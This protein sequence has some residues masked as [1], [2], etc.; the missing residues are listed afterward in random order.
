[1]ENKKIINVQKVIRERQIDGIIINNIKNV[2]YLTGFSGSSG[3]VVI[4]ND[5]G[6]FLTDFR[7][8]EQAL[9]EVK[10]WEICIEKGPRIKAIRGIIKKFKMN[11]IGFED[12][13]S[14][15]F[16]ESL[17]RLPLKLIPLRGVIENLRK[18]KDEEEI[19]SIKKAVKK[20]E[21]AFL[22]VK[23]FIRAGVR[24]RQI[25]LRLEMELKKQGCRHLPF[26]VI[27]AS[28]KNSSM[29][30]ARPTEKKI[31]NGDFVIIDWGGEE[32]GYYS[33]LTRTLLINGTCNSNKVEIYKLVQEAQQKSIDAVSLKVKTQAIDR[34]ARDV[35]K[36]AGYGS[37][38][39]H[40]TGH[41][42]GLDVHEPPYV[43]WFKGEN[44]K[45]GMVF[46]I[47]PGIY[48]PDIGG[49]RIEDMVLVKDG[50]AELLTTLNRELEII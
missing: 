21:T 44:I 1:M 26:D 33:D 46:T 34:V 7:Y 2:Q 50:K 3:F 4:T 5:R 32:C 42:V 40:S 18:I 27:V 10:G 8:K 24:E 36:K 16:Y 19:S 31:E 6:L 14:Y 47:E 23:P 11:T 17:S 35:I 20:A 25:A 48:I 49:V 13:I 39:G 38:F 29:P 43:S 28:G 22:K 12:S 45:E 30:H 9:K 15:E 37:F 41:G